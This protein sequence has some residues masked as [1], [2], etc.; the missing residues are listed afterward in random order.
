MSRVGKK[1]ITIEP[2]VTASFNAGVFSVKGPKGELSRAIDKRLSLAIEGDTIQVSINKTKENLSSLW[3]TYASHVGNM[4]EGVTKGFSKK[5]QIEGIGYKVEMKGADLVFSLG[6][7]HPVIIT[8]PSNLT[9]LIEKN[10]ITI[11]G[12]DKEVVGA[13]AANIRDQKKPEPYKGKG[14]RYEGEFVPQKQGKKSA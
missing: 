4:I 13:F 11:S 9:A 1:I 12:I 14:I 8:V 10:M 6:F 7:S 5:L 3:G 2:G